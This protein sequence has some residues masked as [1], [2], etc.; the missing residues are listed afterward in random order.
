M[1]IPMMDRTLVDQ[2]EINGK[3]IEVVTEHPHNSYELVEEEG[4]VKYLKIQNPEEFW[5]ISKFLVVSI[6]G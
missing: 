3:K 5:K 4:V 2:L 1:N 6:K